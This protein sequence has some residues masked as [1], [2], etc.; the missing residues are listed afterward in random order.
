MC[1]RDSYGPCLMAQ[2]DS[3]MPPVS[4]DAVELFLA[5]AKCGTISLAARELGMVPSVAT[6]KIAALEAALKTRLFERTT[7]RI[8]LTEAGA[9]ALD[10]ATGIIEGYETLADRLAA[11]Q[12]SPS[13]LIRLVMNEYIG[14]VLLPPFL[15]DF[16]KRYP[17]IRYTLTLTDGLVDPDER[18]YDVAV[19]SG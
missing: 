6:R 8:H 13:G 18:G 16:T 12:E 5:V 11:L 10:W 4:L 14:T 2:T 15:A 3:A 1:V 7:R 17:K 19:H 9:V